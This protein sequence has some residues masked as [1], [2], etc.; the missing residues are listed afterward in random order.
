MIT[1]NIATFSTLA[2]HIYTQGEHFF[3]T[4]H[5]FRLVDTNLF[6]GIIWI[7]QKT[8]IFFFNFKFKESHFCHSENRFFFFK[9]CQT[10]DVREVENGANY[11]K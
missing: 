7:Y 11:F 10:T 6:R 3:P 4:F 8:V 9:M 2:K 5:V 1:I